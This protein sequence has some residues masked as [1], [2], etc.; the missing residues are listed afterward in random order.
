LGQVALVVDDGIRVALFTGGLLPI[1]PRAQCRPRCE[2]TYAKMRFAVRARADGVDDHALGP[3][4]YHL[5]GLRD[6][7]SNDVTAV[8]QKVPGWS[9]TAPLTA[10]EAMRAMLGGTEIE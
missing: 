1:G 7:A 8:A 5:V 10:V 4:H 3:Y 9:R 6:C 2:S